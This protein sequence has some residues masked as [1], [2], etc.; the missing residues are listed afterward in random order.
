MFNDNYGSK[1]L[2]EYAAKYCMVFPR[3]LEKTREV[4]AGS[5]VIEE[6]YLIYFRPETPDDI[7]ERFIKDYAKYHKEQKDKRIIVD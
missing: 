7:K 5:L 4:G 3:G 6:D 2:F 1:L